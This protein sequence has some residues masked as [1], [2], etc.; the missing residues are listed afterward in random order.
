MNNFDDDFIRQN[1]ARILSGFATQPRYKHK[2]K[3]QR[4]P[5]KK[6]LD[7]RTNDLLHIF[8][9]YPDRTLTE[10]YQLARLSYST[11]SNIAKKCIRDGLLA[12]ERLDFIQGTPSMAFLLPKACQLLR[13]PERKASGRGGTGCKHMACQL[14]IAR[15]FSDWGFKVVIEYFKN[16]KHA[17]LA[18]WIGEFL[19]ITEVEL[20]IASARQNIERDLELINPTFLISGARDKHLKQEIQNIVSTMPKRARQ[21]VQVCTISELRRKNPQEF[22]PTILV[23]KGVEPSE[24]LISNMS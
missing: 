20:S 19:L 13:L 14:L 4:A 15:C 9:L 10:N 17:D 7:K 24:K 16:G 21:K 3:P 23:S 2:L 6:P 18:V 1:N 11:G 12:I 22:L 5:K 8:N